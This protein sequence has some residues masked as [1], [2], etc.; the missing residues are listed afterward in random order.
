M[1]S[2]NR[3]RHPEEVRKASK[4]DHA[5]MRVDHTNFVIFPKSYQAEA[6]CEHASMR[7]QGNGIIRRE[8]FVRSGLRKAFCHIVGQGNGTEEVTIIDGHIGDQR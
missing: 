8:D 4:E 3:S 6:D 5:S 2:V 1:L 7:E